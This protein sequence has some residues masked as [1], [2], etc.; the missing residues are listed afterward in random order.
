MQYAFSSLCQYFTLSSLI[1]TPA[2][3]HAKINQSGCQTGVMLYNMASICD[4]NHLLLTSVAAGV[5]RSCS[6]FSISSWHI[7]NPTRE[8]N[9][10]LA[11]ALLHVRRN[12]LPDP[13]YH[14]NQEV[15]MTCLQDALESGVFTSILLKHISNTFIP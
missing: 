12:N 3:T 6:I 13:L 8:I 2:A 10:K 7:L 15:A 14:L 9:H 11:L 4:L 5:G 1:C